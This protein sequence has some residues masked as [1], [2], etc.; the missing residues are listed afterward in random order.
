MNCKVAIELAVFRQRWPHGGPLLPLH[1]MCR[2]G[3]P[4]VEET[5]LKK[6]GDAFESEGTRTN[7]TQKCGLQQITISER[8]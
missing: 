1:L 8:S 6:V 3:D 2:L 4:K 5:K 7:T